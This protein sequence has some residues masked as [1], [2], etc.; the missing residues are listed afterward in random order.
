MP[1]ESVEIL[2]EAQDLASAKF[3]TVANNAEA[4]VKRVREVGERAKKSTEFFGTLANSLGGT[5]LGGIASQLANITEKTAQFAEVSKLGATGAFAFKAGLVAVVG[6]LGVGVGRAIGDVVFQTEKWNEALKRSKVEF[7]RLGTLAKDIRQA[8]FAEG[9]KDIEL[10][11]EPE[12]K[13]KHYQIL[14]DSTSKN[15]DTLKSRVE[16]LQTAVEDYNASWLLAF[17]LSRANAQSN[18]VELENAKNTLEIERERA[19]VLRELIIARESAPPDPLPSNKRFNILKAMQDEIQKLEAANPAAMLFVR[20]DKPKGQ[21]S[22][23]EQLNERYDAI[24]KAI[25]VEKRLNALIE[26]EK[27]ATEKRWETQ[28]EIN[29]ALEDQEKLRIAERERVDAITQSERDRLEIERELLEKGTEA[30]KVLALVKQGIN[31]E[32]AKELAQESMLLE[33]LRNQAVEEENIAKIKAKEE[34]ARKKQEED[35]KARIDKL[36]KESPNALQATES[37]LLTR[38]GGVDK[39]LME[40]INIRATAQKQLEEARQAREEERRNKAVRLEL[41]K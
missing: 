11:K 13:R 37:R 39:Q 26:T 38:G 23:L 7:D 41:V 25:E 34:E 3:K 6:S 16:A 4:S 12:E 10:I 5:E 19:K 8:S 15:I 40:L 21:L 22:E 24:V 36:L 2:I 28:R 35:E 29:Q 1:T 31:E 20:E 27:E 9:L 17:P 18:T 32:T 33:A 14:L 30:A